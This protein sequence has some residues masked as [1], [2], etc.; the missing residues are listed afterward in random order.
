MGVGLPKKGIKNMMNGY[1]G[2]ITTYK[3]ALKQTLT[4]RIIGQENEPIV[5]KT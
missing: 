4:K 2:A 3:K 1:G 5:F